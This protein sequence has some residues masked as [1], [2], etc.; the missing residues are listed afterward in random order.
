MKH[1]HVRVGN[2]ELPADQPCQS[3]RLTG[4]LCLFLTELQSVLLTL[5]SIDTLGTWS[6]YL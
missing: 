4:N 6:P 3:L 5:V 2:L 1:P